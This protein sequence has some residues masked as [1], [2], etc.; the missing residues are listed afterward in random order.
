LMVAHVFS[1]KNLGYDMHSLLDV[2]NYF[3]HIKDFFLW[4]HL[5][6]NHCKPLERID[7]KQKISSQACYWWASPTLFFRKHSLH[8]IL[9]LKHTM[10]IIHSYHRE[11]FYNICMT[12][13]TFFW[14][15]SWHIGNQCLTSNNIN[16]SPLRITYLIA[17]PLTQLP[18]I[19]VLNFIH[20][21]PF[22][23]AWWLRQ[24]TSTSNYLVTLYWHSKI[25]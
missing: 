25:S 14:Y 21:I 2:I 11:I 6:N 19:H 23:R 7:R 22:L 24:H 18:N 16:L 5:P 9:F 3:L 10:H 4:R 15:N 8:E 17:L 20:I 12:T 13:S 1:L